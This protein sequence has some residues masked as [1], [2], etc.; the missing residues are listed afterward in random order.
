MPSARINFAELGFG[1]GLGK[2][3]ALHVSKLESRGNFDHLLIKDSWILRDIPAS[4]AARST[5]R[6]DQ[7]E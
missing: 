5:V 4:T 1:T 3:K 2:K 7:H 6:S